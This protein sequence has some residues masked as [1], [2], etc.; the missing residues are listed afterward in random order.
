[1][2]KDY[3]LQKMRERIREL[4]ETLARS[5][6]AGYAQGVENT[7][8]RAIKRIQELEKRQRQLVEME[9]LRARTALKQQNRA[10]DAEA[11]ADEL[12]EVLAHHLR[13]VDCHGR[14]D[15]RCP[16]GNSRK[17]GVESWYCDDCVELWKDLVEK[18]EARGKA[19][20]TI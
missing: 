8:A 11:L 7:E 4:E 6:E 12:G 18:W 9:G 19:K 20:P 13:V 3:R 17:A 2:D 14:N 5:T 1:M 10:E 16:H 15:E